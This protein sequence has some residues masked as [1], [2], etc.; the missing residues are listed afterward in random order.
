MPSTLKRPRIPS[1]PNRPTTATTTIMTPSVSI[2][3][4]LQPT[5]LREGKLLDRSS[6]IEAA[7]A[8]VT[9]GKSPGTIKVL[10]N[11][12]LPGVSIDSEAEEALLGLADQ[13]LA[14]V[15]QGICE[16]ARHRKRAGYCS[17]KDGRSRIRSGD[18]DETARLLRQVYRVR[19]L[20]LVLLNSPPK[21]PVQPLTSII[22]ECNY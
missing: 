8:N 9:M 22:L 6:F 16:S 17:D 18:G 20:F 19:C 4:Y 7:S 21:R 12:Q 14:Q 1:T 11:H 15:C 5:E 13:F 10:L 2:A 3:Q